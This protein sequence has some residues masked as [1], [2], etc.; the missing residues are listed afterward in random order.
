ME[1]TYPDVTVHLSTGL[2]SNAFMVIGAVSRAIRREVGSDAATDFAEKAVV[3]L[4]RRAVAVRH[5]HSERDLRCAPAGILPGSPPS[6]SGAGRVR[7]A[8]TRTGAPGAVGPEQRHDRPRS[9]SSERGSAMTRIYKVTARSTATMVV[10]VAAG[11]EDEAREKAESAAS[12]GLCICCSGYT[13][14]NYDPASGDPPWSLDIDDLC[15]GD[16]EVEPADDAAADGAR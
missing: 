14:S 2:D 12:A 13:T 15:F 9:T 6:W 3:R 16:A 7:P 8:C 4:V 1:I 5:A 11:S 10:T